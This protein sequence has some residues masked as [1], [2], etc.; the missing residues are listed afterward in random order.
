MSLHTNKYQAMRTAHTGA[1][2]AAACNIVYL[3]GLKRQLKRHVVEDWHFS[4][5]WWTKCTGYYGGIAWAQ[6]A[7]LAAL[8]WFGSGSKKKKNYWIGMEDYWWCRQT[9]KTLRPGLKAVA[10]CFDGKKKNNS[11]LYWLINDIV[12]TCMSMDNKFVHYIFMSTVLHGTNP[13]LTISK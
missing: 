7:H 2:I 10:V 11:W 12:C 3:H 8:I 13:P 4:H 1:I 6:F 5:D 9:G